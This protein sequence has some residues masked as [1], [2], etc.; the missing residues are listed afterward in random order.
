MIC[1]PEILRFIGQATSAL[2]QSG[3]G[4]QVKWRRDRRIVQGGDD[5]RFPMQAGWLI[6]ELKSPAPP[7][8]TPEPWG[9]VSLIHFYDNLF[10]PRDMSA[11]DVL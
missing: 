11:T 1:G 4:R 6:S 10:K 9:E 3:C 7:S 2:V 5:T 8:L